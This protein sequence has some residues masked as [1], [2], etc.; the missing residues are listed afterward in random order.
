[1]DP[2][3]LFQ[4]RCSHSSHPVFSSLL[5]LEARALF[6]L[7]FL[8]TMATTS[9]PTLDIELQARH[10]VGHAKGETS[11]QYDNHQPMR[12][13]KKPLLKR[14]FG[15]MSLLGFSCAVL[16]TWEGILVTSIGALLNGGPAGV[17]WGFLIVLLGTMSTFA[18]IG[19]LAS[20]A[21]VSGGQCK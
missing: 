18:T 2:I 9:L 5:A 10:R 12:L 17:V 7:N 15:F 8:L 14:S 11:V 16:I 13:G 19:E 20:M 21:P 1:M 4:H 3:F 6:I